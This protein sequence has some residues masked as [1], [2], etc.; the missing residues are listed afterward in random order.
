MLSILEEC[1]FPINKIYALASSRS[2]GTRIPFKN[3]ELIV[4]DLETFDFSL[5]QI[6]FFSSGASVSAIYAPKAVDAGCVVI[7]NTSQF[8]YEDD[9]PLVVSEVNP[10]VVSNYKNRGIIAN[11]NC[12]TIQMLV[13]LKPIYDVVGIERIKPY[14]E[15]EKRRLMYLEDNRNFLMIHL[16]AIR[17]RFTITVRFTQNK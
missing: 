11:P 4:G 17:V 16:L 15:P 6:G 8:R 2:V 9:V 3:S 7:D 12:S 10:H 1:N 5:V 14:R 13:A